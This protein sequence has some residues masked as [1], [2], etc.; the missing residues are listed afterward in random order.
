M[1]KDKNQRPRLE[2]LIIGNTWFAQKETHKQ[3]LVLA[4]G[5]TNQINQSRLVSLFRWHWAERGEQGGRKRIP[6]RIR[7]DNQVRGNIESIDN[8]NRNYQMF[9][10]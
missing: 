4:E 2:T 9:W 7:S 5:T 8:N 1:V 10:R 3:M 6:P